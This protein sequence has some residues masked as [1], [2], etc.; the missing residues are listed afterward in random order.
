MYIIHK[1]SHLSLGSHMYVY[2]QCMYI[3]V[4]QK[5]RYVYHMIHVCSLYSCL[6]IYIV[7]CLY[8]IHSNA[9]IPYIYMGMHVYTVDW[10][11][12]IVEWWTGYSF[13]V[14]H[15]FYLPCSVSTYFFHSYTYTVLVHLINHS[16][17]S[18]G[19]KGTMLETIWRIFITYYLLRYPSF[20]SWL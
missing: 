2:V 17:F 7:N 1:D 19:L 12:G 14:C 5:T 10:T 15:I 20:E 4:E 9:I 8:M 16:T 18:K 3:H 11:T 13:I 6:F